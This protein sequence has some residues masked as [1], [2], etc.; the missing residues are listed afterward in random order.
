MSRRVDLLWTDFLE[1]QIASIFR[2]E[3]SADEEPALAGG[4]SQ[5]PLLL[6]N[7]ATDC[8]PRICLRGNLFTDTLPSN[9]QYAVFRKYNFMTYLRYHRTMICV[10]KKVSVFFVQRWGSQFVMISGSY[11]VLLPLGS[12]LDFVFVDSSEVYRRGPFGE[13]NFKSYCCNVTPTL[14]QSRIERHQFYRKRITVHKIT[15]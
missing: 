1:E 5:L 14:H 3:K 13:F 8:L 15:P 6:H 4:C 10:P 12:I 9:G 11:F 7:L 2:V